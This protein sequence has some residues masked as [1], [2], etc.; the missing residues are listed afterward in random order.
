MPDPTPFIA[1]ASLSPALLQLLQA[2]GAMVSLKVAADGRYRWCNDAMA[3][4]LGIEAAAVTSTLDT[5]L[6]PAA[7]AAAVRAA[8][9]RQLGAGIAVADTHRFERGGQ[10]LEL[11]AWRGPVLDHEGVA[12]ILTV[13]RVDTTRTLEQRLKQALAQIER[14][15]GA[16]AQLR[17]QMAQPVDGDRPNALFR[18][19]HLEEHL[20]REAS[21]SQRE[22]REFALVLLAVDRHEALVQQRGAAAGERVADTVARLMRANTRAMDVLAQLAPDR[23]AILFSGIGLAT[24]HSRVEQLRRACAAE[25]LVQDGESFGFEISAGV[26]SFPHSAASVSALSQAA[27]RALN[28]ARQRGGNRVALASIALGDDTTAAT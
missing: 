6:L 20:R 7:D 22:G 1:P 27:I 2:E 9:Q 21:M 25:L 13:W 28:D 24:T 15:Q 12:L 18:R 3:A 17:E 11:Q 26:A 5:D 8:D 10:R 4:F 14:Q 19:E 16:L 23:F